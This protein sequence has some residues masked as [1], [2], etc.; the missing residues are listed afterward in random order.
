MK[1]K[2][3]NSARIVNSIRWAKTLQKNK[4]T[5]ARLLVFFLLAL[6]SLSSCTD[7]T[8]IEPEEVIGEMRDGKP[9]LTYKDKDKLKKAIEKTLPTKT[10]VDS[11]FFHQVEESDSSINTYLIARSTYQ[12]DGKGQQITWNARFKPFGPFQGPIKWKD[13]DAP[14]LCGTSSACVACAVALGGHCKCLPSSFLDPL[15]KAF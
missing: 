4:S 14:L 9:E 3:A 15:C 1:P 8:D 12:K 6:A 13:L 10:P 11:L 5:M 7:T 2:I